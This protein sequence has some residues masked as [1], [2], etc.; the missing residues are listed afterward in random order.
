MFPVVLGLFPVLYG[1]AASE[2]T[3]FPF[4]GQNVNGLRFL[5][6]FRLS[7]DNPFYNGRITPSIRGLVFDAIVSMVF[8]R[9]LQSVE[10]R[11]FGAMPKRSSP[12]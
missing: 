7:L 1:K 9:I 10:N 2:K 4:V 6:N 8:R 5:K 12:L 11:E 3:R